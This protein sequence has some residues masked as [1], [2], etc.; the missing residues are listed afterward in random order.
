[1]S[2][3]E[4]AK[5]LT[6]ENRGEV[7]ARFFHASKT[8][9]K[10]VT[11]ELRP[12]EAAPHREVVTVA[13]PAAPP[14]MTPAPSPGHPMVPA[15][16]PD[17]PSGRMS[18]APSRPDAPARQGDTVEPL[19][20]ELRRFHVTVSKRFLA[21]LSAA[22]DV[23]S[24]SHPG[25]DT[26]AIL[27][28]GLDLLLA[29]HDQKKG[30]VKKPRAA[31]PRPSERPRHIPAEVKRAVWTRDGGRCQWPITSGGVC[32][33]TRQ[34]EL[35]HIVPVARGGASTVANLRVTCRQH[36]QLAARQV[37]GEEWMNQFSSRSR[38]A[39]SSSSCSGPPAANLTDSATDWM[40]TGACRV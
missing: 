2:V 3:A 23:L 33:S 4:L 28:T 19:A 5:V 8:E 13:R 29:K 7:L 18:S 16:Q 15:V 9:A 20:A 39:R 22:R 24:H 17:E 37:F 32:G 10:A 6:P 21:K 30:L 14:R 25:A 38:S 40:N 27:E 36:N 11:A 12:M 35:D 26:E 31:P 1:M 34:L